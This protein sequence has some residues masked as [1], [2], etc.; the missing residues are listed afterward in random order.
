M[1]LGKSYNVI[2]WIAIV[3]MPAATALWL[4]VGTIWAIP[5]TT[6]IGATAAAV[7]TFLGALVGISNITHVKQQTVAAEEYIGGNDA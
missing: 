1:K 2:K 7:D 4:A 6:E 3:G 5:L